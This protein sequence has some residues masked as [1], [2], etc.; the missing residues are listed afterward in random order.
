MRQ[1]PSLRCAPIPTHRVPPAA[2]ATS[3]TWTLCC[4]TQHL[5]RPSHTSS[6]G[7]LLPGYACRGSGSRMEVLACAMGQGVLDATFQ[8]SWQGAPPQQ[9]VPG[10]AAMGAALRGP[11]GRPPS[12]SRGRLTS[13]QALAPRPRPCQ[14]C[15]PVHGS[16]WRNCRS[17]WTRAASGWGCWARCRWCCRP[18]WRWRCWSSC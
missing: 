12:L 15:L 7:G 14:P 8:I 3:Q 10:W 4:T 5:Q 17:T 11:R 6:A 16:G 9:H 1:L 2:T 13:R 18:S